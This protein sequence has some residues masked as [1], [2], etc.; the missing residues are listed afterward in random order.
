MET[1]TKWTS[2]LT[3][4]SIFSSFYNPL[5]ITIYPIA[6]TRNTR[7]ILKFSLSYFPKWEHSHLWGER[8]SA[9]MACSDSLAPRFVNNYITAEILYSTVCI[10]RYL[11]GHGLLC[12]VGMY[13]LHPKKWWCY[14]CVSAVSVGS[15]TR[16]ENTACS[17][18][19]AAAPARRE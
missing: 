18:A 16:G 10:M 12:A 4:I 17:A 8:K 6:C 2:Q 19:V 13:E 11:L 15:A 1:F 3:P 14:F 9:K 7:I 5:C